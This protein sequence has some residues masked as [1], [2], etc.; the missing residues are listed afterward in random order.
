MPA[1]SRDTREARSE[2]R[3]TQR[4]CHSWH[5][6]RSQPGFHEERGRDC[7]SAQRKSHEIPGEPAKSKA[8]C[9]RNG[10]EL[11]SN[12]QII[13]VTPFANVKAGQWRSENSAVTQPVAVD[14]CRSRYGYGAGM[15]P[16]VPDRLSA[17]PQQ[18][19]LL[20]SVLTCSENGPA[21]WKSSLEQFQRPDSPP[22]H[23]LLSVSCRV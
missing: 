3:E 23:R 9:L 19:R 10:L 22:S 1:K 18:R 6:P 11:G 17:V 14:K 20:A 16:R 2:R 4:V 5:E 7:S 21:I 12:Q 13:L 8:C 15:A